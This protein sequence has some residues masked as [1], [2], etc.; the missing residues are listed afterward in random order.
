[1]LERVLVQPNRI[2]RSAQW[3]ANHAIELEAELDCEQI[4]VGD[5][6]VLREGNHYRIVGDPDG[7]DDESPATKPI[8][9]RCICGSTW[10]SRDHYLVCRACGHEYAPH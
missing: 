3:I 1:M 9:Q 6:L 2:T 7:W 10:S 4:L 8:R 5:V